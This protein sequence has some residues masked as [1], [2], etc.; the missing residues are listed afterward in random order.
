MGLQPSTVAF[1]FSYI[2]LFLIICPH[3]AFHF[4]F[5]SLLSQIPSPIQTN[6]TSP[7]YLSLKYMAL[8]MSYS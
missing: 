8:S 2:V 4:L 5:Y 3:I 7:I 1:L 6:V